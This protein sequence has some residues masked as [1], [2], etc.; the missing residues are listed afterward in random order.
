LLLGQVGR[1]PWEFPFEA[2]GIMRHRDRFGQLNS[3]ERL[4]RFLAE[5]RS[6]ATTETNAAKLFAAHIRLRNASN[7]SEAL[8]TSDRV[9][10]GR[11]LT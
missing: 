5:A 4:S 8:L 2:N 10:I 11:L 6:A 1:T 3:R 7:T 9:G